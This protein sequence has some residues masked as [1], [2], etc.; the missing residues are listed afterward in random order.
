MRRK[1]GVTFSL[2]SQLEA[3]L[4]SRL[5]PTVDIRALRNLADC[6]ACILTSRSVNS[7]E[8]KAVLPRD[9]TE[10]SKENWISHVLASPLIDCCEIMNG[11]APEVVKILSRNRKTVVLM[12]DQSQI[13]DD[14]QCLMISV[15]FGNRALPI[16]WK[17]IK[18]K[19]NIGFDDQENLLDKVKAMMP[20]GVDFLFTADRFYGTKS[21][22]EWLQKTGWH[23]RLRLKG[24]LIFQHEGGEITSADVEKMPGSKVVGACFNGSNISVNI[25]FLHEKN[26]PEPWIIAMDCEPSKHR[27][28]DYGMRWGIECMFSDFKSRGFSIVDTHL[29]HEDRIER[30][31]LIAT[32]A[33]YWAVSVGITPPSPEEAAFSKKKLYRSKCSP[34]KRGL[35]LISNMLSYLCFSHSMWMFA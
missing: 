16:L 12:M 14:L 24:N 25:G 28:L 32:I 29:K 7:G 23:Y 22:A 11:F 9:S 15:R 20:P 27:I 34:F 10:K 5:Q 35:R 21:L 4:M 33:L 19:G 1:N 30:L 6:A 2:S 8:W 18:T 13:K 26:H 17:I 3:D 31:I